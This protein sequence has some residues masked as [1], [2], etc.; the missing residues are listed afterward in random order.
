MEN[1][2]GFIAALEGSPYP[3][4]PAQIVDVSSSDVKRALARTIERDVIPQLIFNTCQ[5]IAASQPAPLVTPDC[6][7]HSI[8]SFCQIILTRELEEA[9]AYVVRQ[10]AAGADRPEILIKLLALT[11]ERLGQLWDLDKCTFVD[12]TI[13]FGK[14][15]QL[16]RL[17]SETYR[18][19]Q[20]PGEHGF[21]ALLA[22][23]PDNQHLFGLLVVEEL[24]RQ[25]G[26]TVLTLP[27]PSRSELLDAVA[28]E[29]FAVVGLSISCA[30]GAKSVTSLIT[31]IRA[32]SM[33]RGVLVLIGGRFVSANPEQSESLGADLI[34][35]DAQEAIEQSQNFL[36]EE[37]RFGAQ[38]ARS[39]SQ[40]HHARRALR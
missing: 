26:W 31:E 10:T 1:K 6:L 8:S 17:L 32:T 27:R 20:D 2:V 21:R 39:L 23:V 28:R 16:L 14:L 19:A 36:N 40:P 15:Q 13:A 35:A 34:G 37:C 4:P 29:W 30:R 3:T 33:N 22:T 5:L 24:F 11:A 12:V 18:Y 25:S 38:A 9:K 7:P